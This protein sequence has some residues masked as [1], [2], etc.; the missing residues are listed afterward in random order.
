MEMDAEREAGK[1]P[2]PEQLHELQQLIWG[3][4]VSQALYVVAKLGIPD[5]L[6]DGPKETEELAQATQTHASSLFRV[7]RFLAGIGVFEEV[8]PRRFA[9]TALGAGLRT[10]VAGSRHPQAVF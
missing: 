10:D 3:Y 1:T 4:H 8:V 7:L 2:S 5:L 9:L 6:K